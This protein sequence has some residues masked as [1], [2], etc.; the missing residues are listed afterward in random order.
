MPKLSESARVPE[1][2]SERSQLPALITSLPGRLGKMAA[3]K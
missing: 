1:E 2:N 3:R